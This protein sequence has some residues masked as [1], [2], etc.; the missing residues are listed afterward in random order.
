LTA[1]ASSAFSGFAERQNKIGGKSKMKE[2]SQEN[3]RYYLS[4][5]S[6]YDGD[7]FV[8]FNIVDLNTVK[9][10]ITVAI[11][12]EGKI[13]VC[14]FDLKLNGERLFFEYGVMYEKIAV[15]DFEQIEE[16]YGN[17]GY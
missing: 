3:R 5:F 2:M 12:N 10:E 14:T 13:S 17:G 7:H 11:T 8:T 9:N 15:D 6:L 1:A 16:G 4:E